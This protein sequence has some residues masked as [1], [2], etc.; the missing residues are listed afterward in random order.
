MAPTVYRF[1]NWEYL[2]Q[3]GE[4]RDTSAATTTRLEPKVASVLE[5]LL[6][7]P[8]EVVAKEDLISRVWP[9][10]FVSDG[11]IFRHVSALRR[12]L[13]DNA[14]AQTYIQTVPKRG[15]RFAA[16]VSRSSMTTV[17]PAIRTPPAGGRSSF[18]APPMDRPATRP[19]RRIGRVAL[20]VATATALALVGSLWEG[21]NPP[22]AS[23]PVG[24]QAAPV[25]A[26]SPESWA[27]LEFAQLF[28]D[29]VDCSSYARA[30]ELLAEIVVRDPQVGPAHSSL[31]NVTVASAVLG[32]APP[33]PLLDRLSGLAIAAS[34]T[35]R[36]ASMRLRTDAHLR[37]WRSRSPQLA[38]QEFEQWQGTVSADARND[39]GYAAALAAAGRT[40]DAVAVARAGLAREPTHPGTN[41][42]LGL[43]LYFDGNADG[44]VDQLRWTLELHPEFAPARD[45]LALVLLRRGRI[46]EADRM[47][48]GAPASGSGRFATVPALI[49]ALV[50]NDAESVIDAWEARA[51]DAWVAP[52]AMALLL[53]GLGRPDD[54]FEW[55]RQAV[56]ED[57]PW[58]ALIP[59]DPTF[60]R[61][62]THAD[63]PDLA[64]SLT[65]P[66][67]DLPEPE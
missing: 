33:G 32:C 46:E 66:G 63:Y 34:S 47:V 9:D 44:A 57:D 39:V 56:D 49:H 16:A 30:E 15:Y 12:A 36:G 51:A 26:G 52:T 64:K 61:I 38:L 18:D 41:W 14:R 62:R 4:L 6:A 67:N 3:S 7:H 37:L 21:A 13:G 17:I 28:E 40:G 48:R 55:V 2:P 25:H 5:C 53:D 50:S 31:I 24:G 1:G 45:L 27:Q 10:T 60:D 20:A 58:V 29:R 23:V 59:V 22:P 8:G 11:S 43:M 54:A 65:T 19:R 35:R 42:T